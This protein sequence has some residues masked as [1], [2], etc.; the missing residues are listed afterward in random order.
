M[1]PR[2]RGT[3]GGH[4]SGGKKMAVGVGID[5][6]DFSRDAYKAG[7]HTVCQR[8]IVSLSLVVVPYKA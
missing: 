2:G 7:M 1:A 8:T 5:P 4:R 3:S 6:R